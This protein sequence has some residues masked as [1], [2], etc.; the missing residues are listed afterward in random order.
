MSFAP[1]RRAALRRGSLCHIAIA[2]SAREVSDGAK[3]RA[4]VVARRVLRPSS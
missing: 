1:R 4:F 3:A 2:S